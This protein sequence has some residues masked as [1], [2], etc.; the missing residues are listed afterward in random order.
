MAIPFAK[1]PNFSIVEM[2]YLNELSDFS[3]DF[4]AK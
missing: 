1:N 3:Y 2:T 4:M